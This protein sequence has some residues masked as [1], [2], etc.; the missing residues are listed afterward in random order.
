VQTLA[1]SGTRL[2]G[3]ALERSNSVAAAQA[4]PISRG[5]T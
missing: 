2:T 1:L 5:D 3:A 4:A